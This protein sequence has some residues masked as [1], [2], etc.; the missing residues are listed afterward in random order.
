MNQ[1]T[2]PSTPCVCPACGAPLEPQEHAE[3]AP[4]LGMSRRA[5]EAL[6]YEALM[7]DSLNPY[8]LAVTNPGD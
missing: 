5:R 1:D 7:M 2:E 8:T 3:H 6:E 4:A